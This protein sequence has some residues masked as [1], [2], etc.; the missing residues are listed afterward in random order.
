VQA[1]LDGG[2]AGLAK[3]VKATLSFLY[4]GQAQV[5]EWLIPEEKASGV[6]LSQEHRE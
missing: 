2:V 5:Q 4:Q 3:P 6:A 1:I